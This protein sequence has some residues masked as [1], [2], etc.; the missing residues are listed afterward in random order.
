M[1]NIGSK[2]RINVGV[3]TNKTNLDGGWTPCIGVA[4]RF[5][6][7]HKPIYKHTHTNTNNLEYECRKIQKND[8]QKKCVF[9]VIK[10]RSKQRRQKL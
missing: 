9:I 4:T 7:N 2:H 1:F 10:V 6:N 5:V 8:K 3:T